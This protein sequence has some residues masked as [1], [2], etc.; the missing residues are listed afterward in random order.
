MKKDLW[1]PKRRIEEQYRKSLK[2]IT[3]LIQKS[4][5]GLTDPSE[6]IAKLKTLINNPALSSYADATALKMVT[7]LFTDAGRTWRAAASYNSK[8][9]TIYEA[10]KKELQGPINGSFHFQVKRNADIIKT[11]PSS[12]ANRLTKYIADESLKGR[13]AS[14]IAEDIRAR[15]PV[16]TEA[17]INLIARTE[18][19]KTSTALTR[20][21]SEDIGLEFYQWESSQDSRVRNSHEHM[22]GVIIAWKEPPSPEKLI[23]EKSVGNYHAGEVFNCRCFPMPIISIDDIKFP[24]KVYRNG[25]IQVMTRKKFLDIMQ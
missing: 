23:G 14:D 24:C 6:I 10:L 5:E 18:V 8:G 12:T 20:A 1:E 16:S 19:S 3:D 13:R 4:V 22:Q 11:M 21:R 17:N 15:F 2:Q 25:R 7:H 9:R